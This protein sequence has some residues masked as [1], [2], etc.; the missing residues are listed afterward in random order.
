MAKAVK[1]Q[2]ESLEKRMPSGR[3]PYSKFSKFLKMHQGEIE[4]K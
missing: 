1:T 2:I 3:R 4:P